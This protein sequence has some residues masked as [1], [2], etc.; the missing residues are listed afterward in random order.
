MRSLPRL[1]SPGIH[2]YTRRTAVFASNQL[3]P[4]TSG[5]FSSPSRC[6]SE[7]WLVCV[8]SGAREHW[9]PFASAARPEV[10]AAVA[11]AQSGGKWGVEETQP[12]S[13]R[14]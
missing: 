12:E 13:P 5:Y 8:T 9:F 11:E 3:R 10:E 7:A 2:K 4:P 6:L 1:A 14:R